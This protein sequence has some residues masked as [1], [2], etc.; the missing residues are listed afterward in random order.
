MPR[1]L[2]PVHEARA[3]NELQARG[4]PPKFILVESPNEIDVLRTLR[5]RQSTEDLF[6]SRVIAEEGKSRAALSCLGLKR[7]LVTTQPS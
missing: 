5:L 1:G 6:C 3:G 4:G 2:G 7:F